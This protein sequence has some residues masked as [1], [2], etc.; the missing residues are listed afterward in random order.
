MAFSD[1]HVHTTFSDGKGTVDACIAAAREQGLFSLGLSD[2]S[3]T[4]FDLTY[5][6]KSEECEKE[7]EKTVREAQKKARE[8]HGFPVYLGIELDYGSPKSKYESYDYTIGSVHYIFCGDEIFPVDSGLGKQQAGIDKYF[9][10]NQLDFAKAY[11]AQVV[12]H[13]EKNRPTFM[14]H[15]D[16]LTK[17][18]SFNEEN[19]DYKKIVHEAIA[20]TVRYVPTF[21]VSAGPIIRGLKAIPYPNPQFLSVIKECGGKVILSSD[22]HAPDK[23]AYHFPALLELIKAAGFTK[24]SRFEAGKLIELDIDTL[25]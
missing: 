2:H 6:S 17:Y 19:E 5:C 11:Y 3:Y 4:A 14:G 10:G 24:V 18:S 21:E 25:S 13:A 20:E 22:A 1:F 12:A 8:E 7:Y 9:G 23:I 16:L 15:L